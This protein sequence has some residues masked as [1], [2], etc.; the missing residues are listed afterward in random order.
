MIFKEELISAEKIYEGKI[1]NLR[2]DTVTVRNGKTASREIVEHRGAVALVV[3]TEQ[4]KIVM[5]KQ[6]R[7]AMRD[8]MLEIPAGKIDNGEHD[9]MTAAVREL[10]EE[11]GYT[12]DNIR[13]IGKM[14]PSVAYSEEGL[15]LYFCSG[16]TKGERN[17][18]DDE[19]IDVVEYDFDEVC[20][21]IEN[22][23]LGDS[24]TICAVLMV[25][26]LLADGRIS[27]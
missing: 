21:R 7:H 10:K 4:R 25:K 19:A 8:V 26:G 13:Y 27:T 6:Y 9:P 2:K 3:L 14:F 24:K 16:L 12:A 17:L 1:L 23:E 18:D 5:V 11:T 22:G 15:W 20:H